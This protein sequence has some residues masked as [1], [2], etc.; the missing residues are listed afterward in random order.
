MPFKQKLKRKE[1]KFLMRNLPKLK[2]KLEKKFGT[3]LWEHLEESQQKAFK[4]VIRKYKDNLYGKE[5]DKLNYLKLIKRKHLKENNYFVITEL[6]HKEEEFY[7]YDNLADY[8]FIE[9]KFQRKEHYKSLIQTQ[10]Y[11]K[12]YNKEKKEQNKK[13]IYERYGK[14]YIELYLY[15]TW[16]RWVENKKIVYGSI[17]S[18]ESWLID[19]IAEDIETFIKDNIPYILQSNTYKEENSKYFN[20]DIKTKAMGREEELEELKKVL[21]N[22]EVEIRKSIL[23]KLLPEI[24]NCIFKEQISNSVDTATH[25]YIS[26]LETAKNLTTKSF[27]EKVEELEQPMEYIKKRYK[28]LYKELGIKDLLRQEYYLNK[29]KYLNK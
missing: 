16:C 3:L 17:A 9:W 1:I 23:N 20:L 24:K 28:E 6:G 14:D 27:L 26:D 11:R 25:I 4:K 29:S 10:K 5:L 18:I 12:E 15:D 21:R 2:K 7:K 8:S 19:K 13:D 22:K